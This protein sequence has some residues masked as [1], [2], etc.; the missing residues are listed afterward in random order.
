MAIN[1]TLRAKNFAGPTWGPTFT[2][3]AAAAG[4]TAASLVCAP[5]RA[6][7]VSE[8][9]VTVS[10]SAPTSA[11]TPAAAAA[12]KIKVDP[13][14]QPTTNLLPGGRGEKIENKSGDLPSPNLIPADLVREAVDQIAPLTA[15]EVRALRAEIKKR[16]LA[17]RETLNAPPPKPG[18]VLYT[19]DLSPSPS[20]A[21]PVVRVTPGQGSVISFTDV[22]GRPWRIAEAENFGKG[23]GI[24]VARFGDAQLSVAVS[25]TAQI[26]SLAVL[27]E[28]LSKPV[29]VTVM[30]GQRDTDYF[31]QLVV[32]QYLP[33]TALSAGDAEISLGT[34]DLIDFALRTPPAGVRELTLTGLSGAQ[35]W[36]TSPTKMVVRTQAVLTTPAFLRR[37]ESG[38]DSNYVYEVPLSPILLVSVEGK[39]ASVKVSG[40]Q[41]ISK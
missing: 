5:A 15:D 14:L 25:S 35:A 36:Q 41:E 21:P 1:Q 16:E 34:A 6:Q 8:R 40:F 10:T 4:L 22:S 32:P 27:L 30:P 20:T 31:A 3:F 19:L 7:G 2:L 37:R 12:P 18:S 24:Q 38:I 29:V 33:G 26:G 13:K 17:G 9:V 39:F 23:V 28:G 11:P